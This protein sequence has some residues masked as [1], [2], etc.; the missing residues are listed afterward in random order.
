MQISLNGVLVGEYRIIK[1]VCKLQ[2]YSMTPVS[3][4]FGPLL[5][6]PRFCLEMAATLTKPAMMRFISIIII[7]LPLRTCVGKLWKC[8]ERFVLQMHGDV[9]EEWAYNG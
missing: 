4:I 7:A 5:N 3:R 6:R 1:S 9:E 8:N 2:P